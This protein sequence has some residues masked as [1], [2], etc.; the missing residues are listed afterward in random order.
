M[1]NNVLNIHELVNANAKKHRFDAIS[2]SK[3]YTCFKHICLAVEGRILQKSEKTAL[4]GNAMEKHNKTASENVN[5]AQVLALNGLQ[6]GKLPFKCTREE[7][8]EAIR[9]MNANGD[10]EKCQN[11]T[12]FNTDKLYRKIDATIVR[13]RKMAKS[14]KKSAKKS[15]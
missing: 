10:L 6:S 1:K 2:A 13:V 11:Y 5:K 9:I 3:H 8:K 7:I 14:T 12:S 15:K 4:F